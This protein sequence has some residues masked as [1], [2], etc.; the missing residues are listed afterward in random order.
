MNIRTLFISDVHLGTR[1]C[2]AELLLDFLNQCRCERIYLVGDIADG[3]RLR[4]RW[5]WPRTHDAIVATVLA[6]ARSGTR[7]VYLPGNHDA[8]LRDSLG[9]RFAGVEIA[10][11]AI[12]ETADGLRYLVLHG[13]RF[14]RVCSGAPWVARLGDV[15]YRCLLGANGA[16]HRLRR[17]RGLPFWSLSASVKLWTKS[18][19]NLISD[20]EQRL[21]EEA[22]RAGAHG[23]ICGHIHHAAIREEQGVCYVNTGDWVE[24]CTAVVEHFNGML[25]IVSWRELRG[26]AAAEATE[27]RASRTARMAFRRRLGQVGAASGSARSRRAGATKMPA[28]GACKASR[29][30]SRG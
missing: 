20:Y 2:Q 27:V 8:F 30:A 26:Y 19:V 24:S 25:E 12:H 15:A 17:R 13:D 21:V 10:D 7:V 22:R 11:Q 18:A 4:S 14:D 23:V 1:G 16:I 3:W 29:K 28:G 6:K 9:L 5:Y